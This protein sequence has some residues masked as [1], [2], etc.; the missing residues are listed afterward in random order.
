[1]RLQNIDNTVIV[2]FAGEKFTWIFSRVEVVALK[3]PEFNITSSFNKRRV[4]VNGH[5]VS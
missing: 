1:M 3:I 4:P 5:C 2:I